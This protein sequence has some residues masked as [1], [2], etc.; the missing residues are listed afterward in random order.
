MREPINR[1]PYCDGV[2]VVTEIIDTFNRQ[3]V[4][5]ETRCQECNGTATWSHGKFKTND[6]VIFPKIPTISGS[7]IRESWQECPK[8]RGVNAIYDIIDRYDHKIV[9]M[10]TKCQDCNFVAHWSHGVFETGDLPEKLV[11]HTSWNIGD[12]E[13]D[14]IEA[15]VQKIEREMMEI[16]TI[17]EAIHQLSQVGDT[18]PHLS[19][20]IAPALDVMR[21]LLQGKESEFEPTEFIRDAMRKSSIPF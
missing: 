10:T 21:K 6:K 17:R 7:K 1:C 13:R 8:C 2:N 19:S 4:E 12:W 14:Q 3:P 20:R 11:V 9:E 18:E 5:C 15:A 16:E